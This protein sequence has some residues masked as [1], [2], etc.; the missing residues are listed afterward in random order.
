M[1]ALTLLLRFIKRIRVAHRILRVHPFADAPHHIV[2]N[3]DYSL[4]NII[5]NHDYWNHGY[6]LFHRSI[7]HPDVSGE[8]FRDHMSHETHYRRWWQ[9]SQLQDATIRSGEWEMT[10]TIK[11]LSRI[12]LPRVNCVWSSAKA[13]TMDKAHRRQ[14]R[15]FY[16][17][18]RIRP[19]QWQKSNTIPTS[20]LSVIISWRKYNQ[21]RDLTPESAMQKQQR[22]FG[23]SHKGG[24]KKHNFRSSLS[25]PASAKHTFVQAEWHCQSGRAPWEPSETPCWRI[26]PSL[27]SI[28]RVALHI[29]L[30]SPFRRVFSL[31]GSPISNKHSDIVA[32]CDHTS[33]WVH[34]VHACIA[35]AMRTPE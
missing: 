32:I 8:K 5:S 9:L 31:C 17:E 24:D 12:S 16:H 2:Y 1:N 29:A 21:W 13:A 27:A 3:W 25:E 22:Q 6:R 7:E 30:R 19:Y 28:P 26:T 20:Q 35:I 15:R 14:W 23:E 18:Y 11:I 10:D 34:S 33:E 4:R